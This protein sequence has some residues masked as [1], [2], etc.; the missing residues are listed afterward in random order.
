MLGQGSRH[1]LVSRL[2]GGL[3]AVALLLGLSML[4]PASALAADGRAVSAEGEI[5]ALYQHGLG[6]A[7][8]SADVQHYMRGVADLGCV[9]GVVDASYQIMS[10]R[11]ADNRWRTSQ[12]QAG[13]LYAGLLNRAPDAGGLR[14]VTTNISRRGLEWSTG[15]MMGS[16]EYRERLAR[17]CGTPV[18]QLRGAMYNWETAANFAEHQLIEAAYSTGASCAFMKGVKKATGLRNNAQGVRAF[19]GSV[20][21]ITN[22]IHGRLENSCGAA[23]EFLKAA[24]KIFQVANPMQN[25]YNPV[26]IDIDEHRSWVTAGMVRYFT[27]QIGPDPTSWAEYEGKYALLIH[28]PTYV[29]G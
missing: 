9:R 12:D 2:L 18:G 4:A 3:T 19:V 20:G 5:R 14:T 27:Y 11:E 16:R 6:R 13:S 29:G 21:E 25:Q 28:Q 15:E 17:I 23:L 22:R 7:A 10:S 8:S 26:F 1:R 24:V